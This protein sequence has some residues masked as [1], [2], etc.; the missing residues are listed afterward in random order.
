LSSNLFESA[1]SLLTGMFHSENEKFNVELDIISADKTVGSE[2]DGRFV[3]S[4]SSKINERIAINGKV[5]GPFGG[6]NQSAVVGDVEILYR[7]NE[8]GSVNL[9]FFNRENDINYIGEGV[10]YTQGVGISYEVDFDTFK[11]L[12]NKFFKNVKIEKI[13]DDD[14]IDVDSNLP[15]ENKDTSKPNK[16]DSKEQKSNR[17]GRIPDEY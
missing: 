2:S 9:R 7:V 13:S 3:A 16:T 11:E 10:G 14:M 6:V 17:E 15:P 5:G 4:V 8:D 12:A 1:T